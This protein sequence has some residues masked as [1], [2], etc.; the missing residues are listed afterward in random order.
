MQEFGRNKESRGPT[1]QIGHKDADPDKGVASWQP[2][3]DQ[4]L[5]INV[6]VTCSTDI[7]SSRFGAIASDSHGSRVAERTRIGDLVEPLVAESKAVMGL[8]M[9]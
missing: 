8:H 2:P 9:R 4:W 3:R 6:D 7:N 5:K 1:L